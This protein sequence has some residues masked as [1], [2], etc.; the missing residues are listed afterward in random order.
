MLVWAVLGP[1][2]TAPNLQGLSD[3]WRTPL[4]YSQ[5]SLGPSWSSHT[6]FFQ[7]AQHRGL[8]SAELLPEEQ[9]SSLCWGRGRGNGEAGVRAQAL[10][11]ASWLASRPT[12]CLHSHAGTGTP[13]QSP[14]L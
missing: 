13:S 10:E 2:G 7:L 4:S 9:L 14:H 12:P 11:P 6:G 1:Q 8:E 3:T 5:Y